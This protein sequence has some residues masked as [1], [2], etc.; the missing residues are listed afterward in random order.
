LLVSLRPWK[1]LVLLASIF[2]IALLSNVLRIAATGWCYVKYGP[3]TGEKFAHDAAGLL[4]MPVALVL[5]GLEMVVLNLMVVDEEIIE[6]PLILGRPIA[7]GRRVAA[8]ENS[9]Q[10]QPQ[11]PPSP[12]PSPTPEGPSRERGRGRENWG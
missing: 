10:S 11:P 5:V 9:P 6:E 8:I 12:S 4:M 1:Q 3:V 7:K 2:P